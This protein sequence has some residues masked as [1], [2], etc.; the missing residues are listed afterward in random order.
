MF[1]WANRPLDQIASTVLADAAHLVGTGCAVRALECADPS[2]GRLRREVDVAT[3]TAR[4]QEHHR[5]FSFLFVGIVGIVGWTRG[6]DRSSTLDHAPGGDKD[7]TCRFHA[8][9]EARPRRP[10]AMQLLS[11]EVRV[12]R[13]AG[14]RVGVPSSLSEI[15][16]NTAAR[17]GREL[18]EA[19]RPSGV[20]A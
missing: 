10:V 15:T 14:E 6:P 2:I 4:L 1:G 3:F 13:V 16:R 19:E 18:F 20:R 12:G 7:A 8:I 9:L 17:A 5:W 11:R